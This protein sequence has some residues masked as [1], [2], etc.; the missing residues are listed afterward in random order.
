MQFRPYNLI[1]ALLLAACGTVVGNPRQPGGGTGS[2]STATTSAVVYS[3][4]TLNFNLPAEATTVADTALMLVDAAEDFGYHDRGIL[5]SWGQRV[6]KL[7]TEVD[8]V[9]TRVNTIIAS[10]RKNGNTTEPLV[11]TNKGANSNLSAHVA[12]LAAG[13]DYAYEAV[14]CYSG[15][16]FTDFKWSTDGSKVDLIRDFSVK[17][18]GVANTYGVKT[19]LT[20]QKADTTDLTLNTQGTW[21]DTILTGSSGYLTEYSQVH[22]LASTELQLQTV[23]QHS[24][25]KPTALNAADTYLVGRLQ[26]TAAAATTYNTEFAGY[27]AS[28]AACKNGFSET[29]TDLWHPTSLSEPH[30]CIGRPSGGEEFATLQQYYD[31]LSDLQPIG[32]ATESEL[33]DVDFAAGTACN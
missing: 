11:I 2:T 10:E 18:D 32:I 19:H 5:T 12:A 13:G 29:Q 30:F 27:F 9:S 16:V 33:E 15:Q 17:A 7:T 31:A 3:L 23:E 24:G 28:A 4:P 1:F 25:A 20:W 26:P 22:R 6:N 8:N 14:L 21:D